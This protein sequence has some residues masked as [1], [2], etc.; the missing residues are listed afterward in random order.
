MHG[1]VVIRGP[2]S[3]E[4]N[5]SVVKI[6]EVQCL[7]VRKGIQ[8]PRIPTEWM[9]WRACLEKTNRDRECSTNFGKMEV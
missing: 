4:L 3:K 1:N 2:L 7:E 5:V 8:K 9:W 6:V